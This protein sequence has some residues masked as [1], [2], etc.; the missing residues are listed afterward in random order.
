MQVCLGSV[1]MFLDIGR[2]LYQPSR[3]FIF[4]NM[5]IIDDSTGEKIDNS[6]K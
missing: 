2:T 1:S 6:K 4:E 5:I 3:S